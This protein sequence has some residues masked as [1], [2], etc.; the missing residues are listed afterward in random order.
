M[1]RFELRAKENG[2]TIFKSI[3][4]AP[5]KESAINAVFSAGLLVYR[6][7]LEI[8]IKQKNVRPGTRGAKKMPPN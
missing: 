2:K 8:A 7:G 1:K 3:V 4:F 5:T 6:L